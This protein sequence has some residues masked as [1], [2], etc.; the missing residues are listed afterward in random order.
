MTNVLP[1]YPRSNL[2]FTHGVGSYLY[3]KSGEKFLDFGTG[4][5]VNSLGYSNPYLNDKLKEQIDKLWH[6]S[7]VYQIPEQE[8]LAQRLCD[9]SFADYVFFCNSGTEAIEASI[10]I[11]RRYFHSS[12]NL[13][14]KT[15]I[16]SFSGSF[17]GRT[18]GALAAGGPDKLS[19]F[20]TTVNGFKFLEFGDHEQLQNSISKKTA[21]VIIEPIQG[22]GGIREVPRQCLEGLRKVCDENNCL[23]IF[24][25]VQC[26]MGRNRK[27]ICI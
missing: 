12:E 23:L 22:E 16:L 11:A 7:N 24:D 25:E 8:K 27:I 2:E 20:N 19:S 10:K 9:N 1:T 26:G 17:H 13:S 14:H 3:T 15:E 5:A 4:I 18:I 21:A 6:L